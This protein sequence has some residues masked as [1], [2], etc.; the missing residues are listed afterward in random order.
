MDGH[1]AEIM[2]LDNTPIQ[3]YEP[4]AAAFP[5]RLEHQ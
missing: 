4:Y 1:E 2:G 3:H 5:A